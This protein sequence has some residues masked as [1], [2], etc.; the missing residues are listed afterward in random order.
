MEIKNETKIMKKSEV[1]AYSIKNAKIVNNI[2]KRFTK[3][4]FLQSQMKSFTIIDI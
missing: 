2:K 4:F 1:I 3:Y